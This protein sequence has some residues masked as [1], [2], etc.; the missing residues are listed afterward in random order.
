MFFANKLFYYYYKNK[1]QNTDGTSCRPGREQKT[2]NIC[3]RSSREQKTQGNLMVT[4][5]DHA[6]N[7]KPAK[8]K[9]KHEWSV[10]IQEENRKL[11]LSI[12]GHV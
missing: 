8:H 9:A 11:I 4:I 6:E 10:A 2:D 5:D 12:T 7:K 1:E 3:R